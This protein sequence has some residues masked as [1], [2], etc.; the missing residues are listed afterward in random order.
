MSTRGLAET[1][2]AW[3]DEASG[4]RLR[5]QPRRITPP[6]GTVVLE[7]GTT[8]E[9]KYVVL[10]LI[11]AGGSAVVYEAE[12]LALGRKVAIKAVCSDADPARVLERFRR[13]ARTCGAL[14]HTNIA[15]VY[16]V[17]DL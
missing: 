15:E 14:R 9:G 1:A 6:A 5:P 16:D 7:P 10:K 2:D 8:L 4:P 3:A 13:E 12:H 17:G 11:G